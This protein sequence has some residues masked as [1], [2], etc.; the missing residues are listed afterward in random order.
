MAITSYSNYASLDIVW[1]TISGLYF[2]KARLNQNPN[3]SPVMV[4]ESGPTLIPNTSV[5]SINPS[6]AVANSNP[7]Y[8][9]IYSL[10]WE[11]NNSIKYRTINGTTFGSVQTISTG[12]Y[13]Y[14]HRPFVIV[15]NDG[16]ARI[17]WLGQYYPGS[18]SRVV[19]KSSNNTRFWYFGSNARTSQITATDD[20]TGYYVIWNETYDNSTKFTDNTTLSTIYNLNTTGHAVQLSNGAD[21]DNMYALVYNHQNQPYYFKTTPSIGSRYG[22]QKS[23]VLSALNSGR[24]GV[25]LKDSIG[26]FYSL[27]NITINDQSVDFIEVAD[28]IAVDDMIQL[29]SYLISNPI[30][31]SANSTLSCDLIMGTTYTD[32]NILR[33]N[34]SVSFSLDIVDANNGKTLGNL[35]KIVFDKDNFTDF[36]EQGY[37]INLTNYNGSKT[38]QLKITASNNFNGYCLM[39]KS[40]SDIKSVNLAKS[41]TK[42]IDF[43]DLLNVTDYALEQNYPNPFNPTT[44]ISWQF[45]VAS[46]H[47]LKVYDIL[48]NEVVTLVNE[49]REAGKYEVGFDA[50]NLPAG[51]QGL[52]SGVYIYKLQAGNFVLTKKMLLLK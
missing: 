1:Q 45:P 39:T 23:S 41:N 25:I 24:G 20:N 27:E 28:T 8:Y 51:R 12:S 29:N 35:N 16:Y 38:V 31:L 19:F 40:F 11:E 22:L 14:N 5:N 7:Y 47:K 6:I 44:K 4:Q 49:F 3:N 46:W 50:S 10:V 18:N 9:F 42:E 52:S 26:Y 33:E 13:P 21:R 32:E 37:K 48:G 2:Y 15:L 36:A 30:T 17:S 34:N 43:N